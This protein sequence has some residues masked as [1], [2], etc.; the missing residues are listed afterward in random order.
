MTNLEWMK[1]PLISD[2]SK[3]KLDFLQ[4]LVFESENLTT[5]ERMPFF[6]ALASRSKQANIQFTQDEVSR[7]IN[8]LKEFSSPNEVSKMDQALKMF[9]SKNTK[10]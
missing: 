4:K 5:K 6:L 7:I 2:I 8:T 9:H 1:S 10:K 3:E